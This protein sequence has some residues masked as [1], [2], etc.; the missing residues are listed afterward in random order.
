M[1]RATGL[2]ILSRV[3][4]KRAPRE[5]RLLVVGASVVCLYGLWVAVWEPSWQTLSQ[6][7][8]QRHRLASELAVLQQL[9]AQ[10][11]TLRTQATPAPGERLAAAMA[12]T[13]TA[14]AQAKATPAGLRVSVQAWPAQT[15]A[16]YLSDMHE[17]LHLSP[18]GGDLQ[19]S[20][21]QWSGWLLFDTGDPQ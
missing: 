6:A 18:I 16:R 3:W 15:L 1:T 7:T 10:A 21:G 5:R 8:E 4:A 9:Q 17:A 19:Q 20:E 2:H 13:P 11:Q 12:L 14:G